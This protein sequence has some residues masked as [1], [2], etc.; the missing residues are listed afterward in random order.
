MTAAHSGLGHSSAWF[1]FMVPTL[2]PGPRA[3]AVRLAP[4][5]GPWLAASSPAPGLG[6]ESASAFVAAFRTETGV[7]PASCFRQ[8][9]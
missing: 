2:R 4:A 7:T 8:E 9:R 5:A 1:S 3:G 6:Y